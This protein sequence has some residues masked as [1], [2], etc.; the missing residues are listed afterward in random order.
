MMTQAQVEQLRQSADSAAIVAGELIGRQ[1]GDGANIA[2]ALQR[3][4]EAR[5]RWL[6][7]VNDAAAG[8]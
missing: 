6:A 5:A 2:V 8:R 1:H 4:G 3:A 7:A